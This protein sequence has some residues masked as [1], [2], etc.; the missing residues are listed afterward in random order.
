M[1]CHY[2]GTA[3]IPLDQSPAAGQ[4]IEMFQCQVNSIEHKTAE[5]LS[6][7]LP[8]QIWKIDASFWPENH[9]G[10]RQI[11]ILHC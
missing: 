11:P 3:P 4:T 7:P 6:H 8:K 1:S 5:I 2:G 9:T 10:L